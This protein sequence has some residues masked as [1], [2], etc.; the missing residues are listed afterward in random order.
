MKVSQ[1]FL[2]VKGFIYV[3]KIRHSA[4]SIVRNIAEDESST[5]VIAEKKKEVPVR[6]FVISSYITCAW[7]GFLLYRYHF[8]IKRKAQL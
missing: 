4:A 3:I 8:L 6:L 5:A 1:T 2:F 7:Q